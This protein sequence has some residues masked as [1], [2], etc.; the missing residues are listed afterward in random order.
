MFFISFLIFTLLLYLHLSFFFIHIFFSMLSLTLSW[1]IAGF[2]HPFYTFSPAHHRVICD[3]SQSD[4]MFDHSVNLL[5]A[6]ATALSGHFLPTGVF[7]LTLLHRHFNLRLSRLPWEMEVLPWGLLGFIL[8]LEYRPDPSVCLIHSNSQSSYLEQFSFKFYHILLW[9][10]CG[11]SLNYLSLLVSNSFR[12][13]KVTRKDYLKTLW[14]RLDMY[15][16]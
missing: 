16:L 9:I 14:T 1:T 3:T 10:A 6:S 12:L 11:E 15:R 4:F 5:A 2:L 13:F 7:Y 8:I